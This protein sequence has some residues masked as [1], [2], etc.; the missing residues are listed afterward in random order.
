MIHMLLVTY[1]N[2]THVEYRLTPLQTSECTH[3]TITDTYQIRR[4]NNKHQ[5]SIREET[6][7]NIDIPNH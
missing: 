1:M 4:P 3:T 2:D 7:S 5:T 6:S